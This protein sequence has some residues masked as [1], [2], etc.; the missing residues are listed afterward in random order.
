MPRVDETTGLESQLQG[1]GD[2]LA[3]DITEQSVSGIVVGTEPAAVN[4][5]IT[6]TAL[7]GDSPLPPIW[8]C[9]GACIWARRLGTFGL[10]GQSAISGQPMAP[11]FEFNPEGIAEQ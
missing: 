3:S 4:K 1:I 11:I 8:M 9:D 2:G 6:G 5:A 7:Q 10:Y